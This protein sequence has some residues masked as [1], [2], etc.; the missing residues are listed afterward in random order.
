MPAY[1]FRRAS[2]TGCGRC[3]SWLSTNANGHDED[4]GGDALCQFTFTPG[5]FEGEV[6]EH[7]PDGVGLAAK[8]PA[9]STTIVPPPPL[10]DF[11]GISGGPVSPDSI[12]VHGIVCSASEGYSVCTDIV[13]VLDWEVFKHDALGSMSLRQAAARYPGWLS[14]RG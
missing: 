3:H 13:P 12:D 10:R 7:H 11:S 2:R 6:L 4:E 14:I 1:A 9:Y 8:G 5:Y